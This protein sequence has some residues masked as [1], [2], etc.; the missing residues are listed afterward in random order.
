MLNLFE[1][2]EVFHAGFFPYKPVEVVYNIAG[3][4]S[5]LAMVEKQDYLIL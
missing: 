4:K 2:N 3:C 5:L 1:G